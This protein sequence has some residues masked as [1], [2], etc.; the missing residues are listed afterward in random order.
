MNDNAVSND[1]FHQ[2]ID[3]FCCWKKNDVFV[4]NPSIRMYGK[5]P[6]CITRPDCSL[7]YSFGYNEFNDDYKVVVVFP[8][9]DN[10]YE[11]HIYSIKVDSWRR[12]D[13][14]PNETVV[15]I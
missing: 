15:Q 10:Q 7:I 5:L 6:D 13:D 2:W 12:V 14:C 1:L 8:S 9:Y 4:G 3:L 11:I